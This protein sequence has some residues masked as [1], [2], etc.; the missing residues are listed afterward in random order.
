MKNMTIFLLL[1][2]VMAWP[3]AAQGQAETQKQA[4]DKAWSLEDCIEYALEHNTDIADMTLAAESNKIEINTARMSRLPD[5]SASLGGSIYF[6]RS[7]SRDATYI[8]NSQ[9]SGS[10]GVSTSVPVYQGMRIKHNIKKAKVDFEAATHS[11]ELARKNISLNITSLF[12]QTLYDSEMLKI[13]QTQLELSGS[14]LELSKGMYESGR[15]SKSDVIKSE[16]IVAADEA[17][18]TRNRNSLMLSVLNLR[19]AMNLPDSVAFTPEIPDDTQG[20]PD[21][22]MIPALSQIYEE[23]VLLH[24]SILY[25]KSNLESSR[26]ALKSVKTAYHPSLYLSAGYG[27]S[28]YSNLSD[29][30]MNNSTFWEQIRH[31]GNEYISLS[32]SIPIF[33]RNTTR[34]NVRQS[35]INV[36]RQEL[37]LSE[38]QKALKKEIEQAY[39]GA[40]TAYGAMVSAEKALDAATVAFENEKDRLGSGKSGIYDFANAKAEMEKAQA[41]LTHSKYDYILKYRILRFYMM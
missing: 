29:R 13:A 28:A 7:P 41:T 27:N 2:I 11:L 10:F 20:I 15:A 5:L 39:Y 33:S 12:L 19:Q 14:Q 17:S 37:M 35:E 40:V 18:L 1:S 25:A 31:N 4:E 9:L 30:S 22:Q 6:G 16:S 24:P 3:A 38:S 23:S 26:L 34:N 36:R 21:M 32:L 8:D